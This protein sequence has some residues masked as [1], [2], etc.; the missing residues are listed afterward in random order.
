MFS[1]NLWWH[2]CAMTNKIKEGEYIYHKINNIHD[3]KDKWLGLVRVYET[4]FLREI[5]LWRKVMSQYCVLLWQS[6]SKKA[7]KSIHLV[8]SWL[9]KLNFSSYKKFEEWIGTRLWGTFDRSTRLSSSEI[10]RF[11]ATHV[12]LETQK[13]DVKILQHVITDLNILKGFLFKLWY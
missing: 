1:E 13:S 2:P 12:L 6:D 5:S 9:P 8:S 7:F 10:D 4:F 11:L 3:R